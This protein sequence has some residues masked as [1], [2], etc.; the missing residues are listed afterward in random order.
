MLSEDFKD[1]ISNDYIDILEKYSE[2][3]IEEDELIEIEEGLRNGLDVS[4]YAKPCFDFQQMY[5]IRKG[6]Q[7]I[8][9]DVSIY[10]DAK[11][12]GNQ[13]HE[14]RE[15]LENGIDVSSY[16]DP[17]LDWFDMEQIRLELEGK[18]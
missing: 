4:V 13:M 16:L 3:G 5:E 14:I 7:F 12:T 17:N 11:Y 10:A 8:G 9:V 1:T 2:M 6:M 18:L 15:G